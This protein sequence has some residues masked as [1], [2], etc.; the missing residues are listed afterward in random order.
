M[1]EKTKQHWWA[2]MLNESMAVSF[3]FTSNSEY[4]IETHYWET[5]SYINKSMCA[6]ETATKQ[7]DI[8]KNI[9]EQSEICADQRT[10][11]RHIEINVLFFFF[12]LFH[13]KT[14]YNVCVYLCHL[15]PQ[16]QYDTIAQVKIFNLAWVFES[17]FQKHGSFLQKFLS[18]IFLNQMLI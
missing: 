6:F 8:H 4:A 15:H 1:I 9:Y 3:T 2:H 16:N 7:I 10:T 5:R 14:K 12:F 11:F 17:R 13:S 18:H